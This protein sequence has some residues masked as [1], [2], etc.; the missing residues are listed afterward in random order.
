MGNEGT[1][2]QCVSKQLEWSQYITL[3]LMQVV[4]HYVYDDEKQ[5]E[6]GVVIS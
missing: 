4:P 2:V 6:S 5:R 1:A 3:K